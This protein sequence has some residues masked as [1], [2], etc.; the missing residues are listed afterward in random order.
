M[1]LL[2]F[3][4]GN[5]TNEKSIKIY[6]DFQVINT[7]WRIVSAP[8]SLQPI[9]LSRVNIPDSHDFSRDNFLGF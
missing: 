4:K 5:G 2:P 1:D 3:Q 7:R 9:Y 6:I 8:K